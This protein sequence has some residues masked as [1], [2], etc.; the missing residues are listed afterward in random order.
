MDPRE[1]RVQLGQAAAEQLTQY[2]HTLSAEAWHH[3][4]ACAGWDVGDVVAHLAF[5]AAFYASTVARGVQGDTA[6]PAGAPLPGVQEREA[7]SAANAQRAIAHR[8]RLGDQLLATFTGRTA[9][10]Y[11]LLQSL[12]PQD[13]DKP[14]YH[15]LGLRPVHEFNTMRLL[16]LAL[17]TW[18]IQSALAPPAALFPDSLPVVMERLPGI[19]SFL[20]MQPEARRLGPLRCHFMVTGAVPSQYDLLMTTDQVR[21][22]PGG[23]AAADV[24]CGCDTETFVLLMS[25]RLTPQAAVVHGRLVVEGDR[26]LLTAGQWFTGV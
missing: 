21:L 16:E 26:R 24:T 5:G 20:R 25:G 19:V 14:C 1:H 8:A 11:Q 13:W 23:G 10:F 9:H 7:F 22:E 6:P 18:D 15:P 2:L 4:S 3:P 12:T 17:H